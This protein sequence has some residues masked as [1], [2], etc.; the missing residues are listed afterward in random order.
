MAIAAAAVPLPALSADAPLREV[1]Y[2]FSIDMHGFDSETDVATNGITSLG[3]MTMTGGRSGTLTVDVLAATKDGGLL[4]EVHENIDRAERP[5]Q[6]VKCAVYENPDNVVCDQ[7]LVQ[8]GVVT[9][10]LDSLLAYFGRGFYDTARLDN[11]NHWQTVLPFNDGKA[12]RTTDFTVSKADGNVLTIDVNRITREGS[13][14]TM[15]KGTLIYD[16][17]MTV[18]VSEHLVTNSNEGGELGGSI[19]DFKLLK[20]SFAKKP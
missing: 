16:S 11:N 6:P 3:G 18:P 14:D 19:F 13:G 4:V 8:A 1:T 10:E 15:A 12:S 9:E 2:H 5:M 17:G 20:D 7:N